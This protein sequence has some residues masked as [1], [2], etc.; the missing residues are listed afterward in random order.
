M[1]LMETS[2]RPLRI[3]LLVLFIMSLA[4]AYLF[5][6]DPSSLSRMYGR[7]A[8]D[9]MHLFLAMGFGSL[10]VTLA[11]GAFLNPV[12]NAAIVLLL[13]VAYFSLFLTDVIVLARAQ[14]PLRSLIPEMVFYLVIAT[15]LIR[16]FPSKE[17]QKKEKNREVAAVKTVKD[18]LEAVVEPLPEEKSKVQY[19]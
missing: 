16:F 11:I 7:E 18:P 15:L 3:T 8:L 6:L 1:W 12:K 17:K 2:H 4:F 13:V 10:M 5:L 9:T 14:M 19:K